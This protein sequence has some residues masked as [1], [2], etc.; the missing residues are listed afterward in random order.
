[1]C[2]NLEW[3]VTGTSR[4]EERE[5]FPAAHVS[6]LHPPDS[7]SRQGCMSPHQLEQEEGHAAGFVVSQMLLQH[8]GAH[9][10]HGVCF[11]TKWLL[12]VQNRSS[13]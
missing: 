4:E 2:F 5:G 11:E 7:F 3:D 12:A 6:C 1:M 8:H 10:D 9:Q 13:C